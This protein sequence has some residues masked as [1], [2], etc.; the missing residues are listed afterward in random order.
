LSH[1]EEQ[2]PALLLQAVGWSKQKEVR[3]VVEGTNLG[4]DAFFNNTRNFH[5]LDPNVSEE[6]GLSSSLWYGDLI[7]KNLQRR[8]S[9]QAPWEVGSEPTTMPAGKAQTPP[10]ATEPPKSWFLSRL[11]YARRGR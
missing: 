11:R 6:C 1:I 2:H 5:S 7:K 9:P 10:K 3:P 8:T 4:T